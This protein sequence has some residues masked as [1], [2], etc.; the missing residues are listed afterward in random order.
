M[1][2]AC[3]VFVS[4]YHAQTMYNIKQ[5]AERAGVTIPVLRAWERRY[6]IVRPARTPSGYRR[7]DDEAIARVRAMRGL[8]DDGWSPSAAAAAIV[9]G[10][11]VVAADAVA[12]PERDVAARTDSSAEA[13]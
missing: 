1:H 7:F 11:V 8:V 5:A 13:A 2:R 9:A 6:G 3:Q 4:G 10:Q 12:E